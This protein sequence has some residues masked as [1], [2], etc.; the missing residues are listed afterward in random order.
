VI[1][2]ASEANRH[3]A[4][5]Q[6]EINRILDVIRGVAGANQACWSFGT[7]L[8]E[9]RGQVS[10]AVFCGGAD[11]VAHVGASAQLNGG[12]NSSR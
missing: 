7:L 1:V 6:C 4:Y 11:E 10:R 5:V 2:E 8:L 3:V 12:Q 9:A